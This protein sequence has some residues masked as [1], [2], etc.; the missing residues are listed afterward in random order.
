M[1]RN[2]FTLVELLVVVAII[3]VLAALLLPSLSQALTMARQAQCANQLHQIH[4]GLMGYTNESSDRLPFLI[5]TGS[6][7]SSDLRKPT[8]L[9]SP[10][11]PYTGLG[12]LIGTGYVGTVGARINQDFFCPDHV[13]HGNAYYQQYGQCDSGRG[14]YMAGWAS[15][16]RTAA[17]GSGYGWFGSNALI[18]SNRTHPTGSDA[19]VGGIT[20]AMKL[21]DY[22]TG[23]VKYTVYGETSAAYRKGHRV[24]VVDHRNDE[25]NSNPGITWHGSYG[26]FSGPTD[27]PHASVANLALTDGAVK[28]V[29]FPTWQ[30]NYAMWASGLWWTAAERAVH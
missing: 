30:A 12:L 5:G 23:F 9:Y 15:C 18:S 8:P 3:T 26:P 21:Q 16:L 20:Y 2:A 10:T 22:M 27:A 28:S 25:W 24:L 17:P 14:D 4:L 7:A 6:G 29:A 11:Y 19:T 13:Y 1:R